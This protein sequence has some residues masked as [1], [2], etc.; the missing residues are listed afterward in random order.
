MKERF[1]MCLVRER[2]AG[3]EAV[4]LEVNALLQAKCIVVEVWESDGALD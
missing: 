1:R 4:A 3:D 2:G